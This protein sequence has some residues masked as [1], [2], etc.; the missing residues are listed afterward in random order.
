MEFEENLS[1][2][3]DFKEILSQQADVEENL[4]PAVAF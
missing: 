3:V 2:A 4:F 1:P